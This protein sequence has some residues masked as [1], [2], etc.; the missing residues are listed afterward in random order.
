V[1][2]AWLLRRGHRERAFGSLLVAAAVLLV[3]MVAGVSYVPGLLGATPLAVAGLALGWRVRGGARLL[4]IA[5]LGFAVVVATQFPEVE[6]NGYQWAG[7]YV[8]LSGALAAIV[9][10]TALEGRGRSAVAAAAAVS[11][12][13]SGFGVAVLVQRT[14]RVGAWAEALA[15]RPESVLI[16]RVPYAF[17]DAGAT[18]TVRSRW[19]LASDPSSVQPA[20]D[21]AATSGA[22]TVA[23]VDGPGAAVATVAGWCAGARESVPWDRSP[24]TL[25][26]YDRAGTSAC[27]EERS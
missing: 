26:H 18:Y 13:V 2:A 4:V 20:F 12:L 15:N 23:L 7:R 5:V 8:L 9:G 6:P 17:R 25:T 10:V 22:E 11:L 24:A 3:R 19:L 27:P 1:R 16:S 14:H 21:L